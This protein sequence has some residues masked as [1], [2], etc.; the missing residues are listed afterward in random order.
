MAA[1]QS[2]YTLP[3]KVTSSSCEFIFGT[4]GILR[5]K[6]E[7]PSHQLERMPLATITHK[8][9]GMDLPTTRDE[10]V[11]SCYGS[12]LYAEI[13]KKIVHLENSLHAQRQL[14]KILYPFIINVPQEGEPIFLRGK[15]NQF[16]IVPIICMNSLD[17]VE[18][19]QP[20]SDTSED[21]T[22]GSPFETH[23][24]SLMGSQTSIP[25][26]EEVPPLLKNFHI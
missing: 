11:Y 7:I 16:G 3:L 9:E 5:P 25:D 13:D 12:S 6:S 14:Q 17:I 1:Q 21:D 19:S 20:E 24:H 23:P 2:I 8:V 18:T 26:L 4:C 10:Y 15:S 22:D